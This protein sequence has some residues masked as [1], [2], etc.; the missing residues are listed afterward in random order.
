MT[1]TPGEPAE[2][3]LADIGVSFTD[4]HGTQHVLQNV[5]LTITAGTTMVLM[6]RTGAGKSTLVSLIPRL[7]D[8]DQGTIT[9]ADHNVAELTRTALSNSVVFVAQSTF[10]FEDTVRTNVTLSDSAYTDEQVWEALEAAHIADFVRTLP[11]G[12][13]TNLGER[14]SNLS[15]GQ[16]QRLAIARA[17]VRRPSVL[18]LD[19]ATSALDPQVE[20]AILATVRQN[21]ATTVIMV[22]YRAASARL[23]DEVCVLAHGNIVARGTHDQLVTTNNYYQELVMAYERDAEQRREDSNAGL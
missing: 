6:G 14:G 13:N 4:E 18:I 23:A 5:T 11:K 19:D 8:P 1:L 9:I 12:I 15:G 7:A 22:A 17:L 20:Q 16:R 2:V 21:Y 3:K 10:I